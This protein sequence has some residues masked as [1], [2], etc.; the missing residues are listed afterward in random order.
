MTSIAAVLFDFQGTI[1]TTEDPVHWVNAAAADCG[2]SLEPARAMAL[3]DQLTAAGRI[4]GPRPVQVP[5]H[6]AEAWARR[7][8][9]PATHRAAYQGLA[10]TV[11]A[12][13]DGFA[14]ALYARVLRAEGWRAYRDAEPTLAA[15]RAAGV[16]VAVVSNVAFNIR[17]VCRRLG[18]GRHVDVW[19]LSYEVGAIKPDPAIFTYA[20][21]E[22]GVE[23][24]R[25]L[26]VGDAGADAGAV[27]IGCRVLILPAAAPGEVN[28]LAA[29]L[30][31]ALA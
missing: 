17:P 28:G 23:P 11:P 2:V 18:F 25:T 21:S 30:A 19:A 10:A 15:L 4:G 8:L 26:M 22:L 16:G 13:I 27:D 14:E 20:C 6:L 31:L 9:S 12:G 5:P 3:A 7:D 24:G 1:A 29:V